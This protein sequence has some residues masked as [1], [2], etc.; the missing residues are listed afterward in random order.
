MRSDAAFRLGRKTYS[1]GDAGAL[2]FREVADG[3]L[4]IVRRVAVG[5]E[6][7]L[8]DIQ[9]V[10]IQAVLPHI[11]VGKVYVVEDLCQLLVGNDPR[12]TASTQHKSGDNEKYIFCVAQFV[13]PNS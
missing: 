12:P 5:G 13:I 9:R 6:N 7:R 10:D 1:S 3:R 2:A 4:H 8:V 11:G